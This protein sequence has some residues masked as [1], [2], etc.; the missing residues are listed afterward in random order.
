MAR[1]VRPFRHVEIDNGLFDTEGA[2]V[3]THAAVPLERC[4]WCEETDWPEEADNEGYVVCGG[5]KHNASAD[6][7]PCDCDEDGD[8]EERW[9]NDNDPAD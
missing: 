5:C 8:P 1:D 7:T 2:M 9:K 4:A 6:L 3:W